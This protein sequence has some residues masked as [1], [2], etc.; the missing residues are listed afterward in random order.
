MRRLIL[1]AVMVLGLA[2]AAQ[3]QIIAR[4]GDIVAWDQAQTDTVSRFEV[5]IGGGFA[6]IGLPP[7]QN[8]ANTRPGHNTYGWTIPAG[9][10]GVLNLQV[11]ACNAAGLPEQCGAALLGAIT[12]G[13][14][15]PSAPVGP[16]RIIPGGQSLVVQPPGDED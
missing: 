1:A 14:P 13:V 7:I 11:R 16:F 2:T 5:N 15:P 12:M 8:D 9:T 4:P 10:T 6:T 3:A